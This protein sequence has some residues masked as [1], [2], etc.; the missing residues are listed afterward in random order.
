MPTF[1]REVCVVL[2]LSRTHPDRSGTPGAVLSFEWWLLLLWE[3]PNKKMHEPLSEV[4]AL[5][6][7]TPPSL[8]SNQQSPQLCHHQP[9]KSR[10]PEAQHPQH[11]QTSIPEPLNSSNPEFGPCSSSGSAGQL[12][13]PEVSTQNPRRPNDSKPTTRCQCR[14]HC[15]GGQHPGRRPR[16]GANSTGR[17]VQV[18]KQPLTPKLPCLVSDMRNKYT[19]LLS[20]VRHKK[21]KLQIM[22]I[23]QQSSQQAEWFL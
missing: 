3:V 21:T 14:L 7:Q 11:S 9:R 13:G 10:K 8:Q 20:P 5:M 12:S 6:S 16:L 17:G 2:E 1:R 4:G 15:S 19:T 18:S 23:S 22:S